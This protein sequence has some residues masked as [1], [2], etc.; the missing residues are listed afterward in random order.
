MPRTRKF[1]YDTALDA[2]VSV[3]WRQ[4]YDGTSLHDLTEAMG[5]NPP[6]LYGAF[7]N[8]RQLFHLAVER[9]MIGPLKRLEQVRAEGGAAEVTRS[10]LDG[11]LED[12]TRPDEAPGCFMVQGALVCADDHADAAAELADLRKLTQQ[13]LAIAYERALYAGELRTGTSPEVL[14]LY[15]ST[16]A[17]GITVQANN[18]IP[19]TDLQE[20]I[21]ITVA[22]LPY[23]N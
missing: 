10:V 22:G 20:V 6:S 7:G 16:V 21:D 3:F 2:A 1:D 18:G 4:G 19:A 15:V 14:A 17:M 9:Y 8:K 11:F 23:R 12:S 13:S 5:V